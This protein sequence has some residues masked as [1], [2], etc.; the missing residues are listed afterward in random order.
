LK[1]WLP[2]SLLVLAML[3]APAQAA[4]LDWCKIVQLLPHDTR[5]IGAFEKGFARASGCRRSTW[6]MSATEWFCKDAVWTFR[7]TP[8]AA[9]GVLLTAKGFSPPPVGA[10]ERCNNR[11]WHVVDRYD[12]GMI[13]FRREFASQRGLARLA[14]LGPVEFGQSIVRLSVSGSPRRDW[15][16]HDGSKAFVSTPAG[17]VRSAVRLAGTD[18]TLVTEDQLMDRLAAEGARIVYR[19]RYSRLRNS[20]SD[21][22]NVDVSPP[23][24]LAG[25]E[26]IYLYFRIDRLEIFAYRI[27]TRTEFDRRIAELD[28]QY[29]PG[30]KQTGSSSFS[31]SWDERVTNQGVMRITA[32]IYGYGTAQ[33]SY[34]INYLNPIVAAQLDP[35]RDYEWEQNEAT[36]G[37]IA[38]AGSAP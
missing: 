16:A 10:I 23:T 11:A 3:V 18:P 21:R 1:R 38:T 14:V 15:S 28:A 31:V 19:P 7:L 34:S 25:V 2:P 12:P 33:E 4:S 30:K 13:L 9:D 20:A 22:W 6:V 29:G 5:G 8:A 17:G 32:I 26:R 37:I 36:N 35:V 27:V 24:T